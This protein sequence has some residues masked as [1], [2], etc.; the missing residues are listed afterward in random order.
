VG[1]IGAHGAL[2]RSE[3]LAFTDALLQAAY[4]DERRPA[5]LGGT[6]T[7]PSNAPAEFGAAIG[8][9]QETEGYY[10]E[11]LRQQLSPR[12]LPLVMWD[13][14]GHETT[15]TYDGYH[16]LPIQVTDAKGLSITAEYNMRLLQP[17]RMTEPN[18]AS[19]HVRYN[20]IGLP[21]KQF[22]VGLDPQGNETLG[23]TSRTNP[24]SLL[25]TISATSSGRASPSLSTPSAASTMPATISRTTPFSR[26]NTPTVSVG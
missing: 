2:T 6:A 18:G 12:G 10:A 20:P 13:A 23:G 22:V 9:H 19:T 25:F 7:L 8:Y 16:L 17:A 21:E 14:L 11:T 26:A 5:Y 15:I 3:A 24:K 4:G 1:Q